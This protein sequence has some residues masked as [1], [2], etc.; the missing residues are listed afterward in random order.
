MELFGL[1]LPELEKGLDVSATSCF[2]RIE[3]REHLSLLPC[4]IG[5]LADGIT[6]HLSSKVLRYVPTLGGVLV[7]YSKPVVLQSFGKIF[8]EQPHI[9]FDVR[10]S[11]YVFKPTVGT[12][13]SGTVNKIGGDH[14]GCLVYDCFNAS[15]IAPPTPAAVSMNGYDVG[16]RRNL[17]IGSKLWFRVSRLEVIGGILSI[18][19]EEVDFGT[20]LGLD[21]TEAAVD[22]RVA[23]D[24]VHDEHQGDSR[25]EL[26]TRDSVVG[27]DLQTAGH[28][29]REHRKKKKKKNKHRGR[30]LSEEVCLEDDVIAEEAEERERRKSRKKR[31]RASSGLEDEVKHKPKKHKLNHK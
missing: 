8:D 28:S 2:R 15:L 14:V 26:D 6:D 4:Y 29:K 16:S 1:K 7:S 12:I 13:L 24:T 20:V 23:G 9:H 18:T 17:R 11:A 19:G 3:V 5:R 10:Y 27:D 22:L 30:K 25:D 31:K 21:T